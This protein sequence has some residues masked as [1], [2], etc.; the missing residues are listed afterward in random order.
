MAVKIVL[1][2]VFICVVLWLGYKGWRRDREAGDYLLAGRQ[3]NPLL[4]ALSYGATFISTA[5]IIGFGGAA[6]AFG[7]PLLWLTVLNIFVGIFIAMTVFGKRTRRMGVA[8]DAHTFPELLG[9]RY[10]SRFVQGF[11]GLLIFLFLPIYSAAVLIGVARFIEVN[12]GL[13]YSWAIFFFMALMAAYVIA[14]GLKSVLYTDAF[15]SVL[16]FLMMLGLFLFTYVKLGGFTAAHQALG[17]LAAKVPAELKAQGMQGWTQGLAAGSPLWLMVYTT[18]VYAVGI[19]VLAQPQL[20]VRYMSQESDRSLNRAVLLGGVFTLCM[21]G[22]AFL[23]GALSN[24]FFVQ[25]TGQV[26]YTLAEGNIDRIIPLF[27]TNI[28]PGWFG[29]LFLLAMMAAAVS[30]LGSHFHVGGASLGRD[31]YE[32]GLGSAGQG[33]VAVTRL[34]VGVTILATLIWGLVLPP[35]IIARATAFFFGLCAS[36]FLPAYFLGL[37]WK[38][39]TKTGAV[40]SMLGGAAV[41]FFL[42]AFVHVKESAA[43]GLC[44]SMFGVDSLAAGAAD[45]SLTAALQYTDPNLIALPAALALAVLV[46]LAGPKPAAAH[47]ELCWRHL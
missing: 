5:A 4:M 43:L 19:G 17:D 37:Y 34:G 26:A 46:S 18:F 36:V 24:V 47:V 10:Q 25:Q 14:G 13:N 42:T 33:E 28:L 32:R 27:V 40:V 22:V 9:R 29:V 20:V 6:G 16:V 39:M 8:L 41:S 15:Q 21:T 35:S 3:A 2:I 11:A 38:G 45:G 7:L 44:R 31:F 23:V 30:T 12:L 1:A